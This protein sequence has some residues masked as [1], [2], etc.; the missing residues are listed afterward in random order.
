MTAGALHIALGPA[1][2]GFAAPAPAPVEALVLG[3]TPDEA[4]ELL[5]RLFNLCR[6]AQGMGARLAL[7]LPVGAADHAALAAEIGRE[8]LIRL[9]V[10]WPRRLGLPAAPL[11]GP[12]TLAGAV[13]GRRGLPDPAGFDGW[14]ASG[15]GVAPV[16]AAIAAAF[17][18]GEAV[19]D[20]PLPSPATLAAPVAQENSPV[21]RHP[22]APLLAEVARRFGRGPLWRAVARLIDLEAVAAGRADLAPRR[23]GDWVHVAAARG[24][25]ALSARVTGGR[26]TAL[27]RRT[28]TDHLLAGGGAL[29]QVLASLPPAK[30]HLAPLV[31]D[32]LDP[33]V[34]VVIREAQHA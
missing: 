12:D 19:A 3:R 34:P 21:A 29:A 20:V 4:A 14:L 2:P 22:K 33:C 25:Y 17:G 26:V 18:P 15:Q 16:L 27:A 9:C 5:P 1:G 30:A 28:P 23:H 10:L 32:I 8:H 6:A 24:T 31:V 11:P 7:G 13:F